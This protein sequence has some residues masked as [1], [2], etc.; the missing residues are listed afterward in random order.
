MGLSRSTIREVKYKTWTVP[1]P[2]NR[3]EAEI[4]A[5]QVNHSGSE[6]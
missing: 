6:I 3:C 5:V 2:I 1:I 4:G